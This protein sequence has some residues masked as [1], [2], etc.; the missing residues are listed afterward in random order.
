[1]RVGNSRLSKVVRRQKA[2]RARNAR[3][4][5]DRA[6]LIK[7]KSDY[8]NAV[9]QAQEGPIDKLYGWGRMEI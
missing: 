5:F 6:R 8:N 2:A 9:I 3:G 7:T 4:R 1:M